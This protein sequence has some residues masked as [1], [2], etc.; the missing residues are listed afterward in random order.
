MYDFL[1]FKWTLT[2]L[3]YINTLENNVV[4]L[5]NDL[6]DWGSRTGGAGDCAILMIEVLELSGWGHSSLNDLT[7]LLTGVTVTRSQ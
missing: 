1:K 2:A 4:S 5:Q 3:Y 7:V 6:I